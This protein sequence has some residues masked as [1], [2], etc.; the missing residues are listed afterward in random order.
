SIDETIEIGRRA[1]LPVHISHLKSSKRRNWGKVRAAAKRIEAAR[2]A[3][4]VVTADQYPYNASS[5]SV[6]AMLLPDEEREE[7]EKATIERLKS[8]QHGPRLRQLVEDNLQGR[9]PIMIADID[10]HPTWIGKML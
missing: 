1:E 10:D 7:G 6:A 9:G 8:A 3:G 4:L 5:T 2:A